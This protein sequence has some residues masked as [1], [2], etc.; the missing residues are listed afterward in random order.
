MTKK[1]SEKR[2]G[3][4]FDKFKNSITTIYNAGIHTVAFGTVLMFVPII[5]GVASISTNGYTENPE[6]SMTIFGKIIEKLKLVKNNSVIFLYTSFVVGLAIINKIICF[7]R[8]QTTQKI[9]K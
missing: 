7:I 1:E 6:N 3:T 2:A 9:S 5:I 4:V 8:N